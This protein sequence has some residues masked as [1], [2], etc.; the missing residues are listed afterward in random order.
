[1]SKKITYEQVIASTKR[2]LRFSQTTI[3]DDEIEKFV[4]WG[5]KQLAKI[6]ITTVLS[7]DLQIDCNAARLPDNC[8]KDEILCFTLG[9]GCACGCTSNCTDGT[10]TTTIRNEDGTTVSVTTALPGLLGNCGCNAVYA[11]PSVLT[12][13]CGA[14]I[15]AG[16]WIN[17]FDVSGGYIKVP[18]SCNS[19]TIKV[20]YVGKYMDCDGI[21]MVIDDD[22][23]PALSFYAASQMAIVYNELFTPQQGSTWATQWERQRDKLGAD[24]QMVDYK[25]RKPFIRAL[26]NAVSVDRHRFNYIY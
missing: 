13:F 23:E 5:C 1:M 10:Q 7:A 24:A 3:H 21:L 22:W 4:D 8:Q 26:A 16:S 14:G 12:N 20:Y 6:N 2:L 17:I 25:K 18:S 19:T 11:S 15:S 9:N